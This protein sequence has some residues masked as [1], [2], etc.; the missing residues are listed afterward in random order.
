MDAFG[1][2][3]ERYQRAPSGQDHAELMEVKRGQMFRFYVKK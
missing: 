1:D 2:I 3:F